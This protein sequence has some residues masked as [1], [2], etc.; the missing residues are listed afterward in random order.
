MTTER[1]DEGIE[2]ELPLGFEVT[3]PQVYPVTRSARL[4]SSGAVPMPGDPAQAQSDDT[5]IE[6][7]KKSGMDPR[8]EV[9]IRPTPQAATSRKRG[10][11]T[12]GVAELKIDLPQDENAV[13]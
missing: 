7:L 10:A 3:T 2:I 12:S 13:L 8:S 6:S 11:T 4:I 5:V 1:L 9:E